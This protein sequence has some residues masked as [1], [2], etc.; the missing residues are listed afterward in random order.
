MGLVRPTGQL[1]GPM[2][3]LALRALRTERQ[4]P[5]ASVRPPCPV[6]GNRESL[7]RLDA[8]LGA[9]DNGQ[10]GHAGRGRR[11]QHG[12]RSLLRLHSKHEG[13]AALGGPPTGVMDREPAEPL[14]SLLSLRP[15]ETPTAQAS[16]VVRPARVQGWARPSLRMLAR[17]PLVVDRTLGGADDPGESAHPSVLEIQVSRW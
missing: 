9:H 14:A 7:V 11:L 4:E 2:P 13:R 12:V 3:K 5:T 8:A 16:R 17:L 1:R 15:T 10:L 6:L